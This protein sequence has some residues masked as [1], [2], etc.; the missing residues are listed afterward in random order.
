[1]SLNQRIGGSSENPDFVLPNSVPLL[2]GADPEG[3]KGGVAPVH[4]RFPWIDTAVATE[5]PEPQRNQQHTGALPCTSKR[6]FRA[7]GPPLSDVR[8][9]I[10]TERPLT[11]LK[12]HP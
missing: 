6:V 5:A 7:H 3:Q 11:A 4:L 8:F 10:D 12:N 2:P 1:M 9:P